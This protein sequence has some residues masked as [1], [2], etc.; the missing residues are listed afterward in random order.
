MEVDLKKSAGKSEEADGAW[1]YPYP[2][3][4]LPPPRPLRWDPDFQGRES[5]SHV[6]FGEGSGTRSAPSEKGDGY[7]GWRAR[8][9][10]G[11]QSPCGWPPGLSR[12]REVIGGR[13]SEMK[14]NGGEAGQSSPR[15][16]CPC[17]PGPGVCAHA[18]HAHACVRR[19][20]HTAQGRVCQALADTCARLLVAG[21]AHGALA[22][23]LSPFPTR[24]R[25]RDGVDG[26]RHSHPL[27]AT[28]RLG[29]SK[30]VNGLQSHSHRSH[31]GAEQGQRQPGRGH[32]EPP[33][34]ASCQD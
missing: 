8:C 32:V 31:H 1:W 26:A 13:T 23:G 22:S 4:L 34:P 15:R 11:S 29:S 19:R 6:S 25:L 14:G 30:D 17:N 20:R 7:S 3:G 18:A 21:G 16:R 2:H 33:P 10:V 28:V 12:R 27:T 5:D 24:T 9:C